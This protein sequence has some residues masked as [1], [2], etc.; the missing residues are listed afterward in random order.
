MWSHYGQAKTIISTYSS[1][2][3]YIYRLSTCP[4]L[5][6]G[7]F[8]TTQPDTPASSLP[9]YASAR[10]PNS[11][12]P[13]RK[14]VLIAHVIA[15]KRESPVV[16]DNAMNVGGHQEHGRTIAIHSLAVL[17]QYQRRNLGKTL[18]KAYTQRMESA[19]IADRIALLAHPHLSKFYEEQGFSNKGESKCKSHGGGWHDL[20]L[21]LLLASSRL[22]GGASANGI[23]DIRIFRTWPRIL[24]LRISGWSWND[25]PKRRTAAGLCWCLKRVVSSFAYCSKSPIGAFPTISIFY[26]PYHAIV[27][28]TETPSWGLSI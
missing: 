13:S 25:P 3:K 21:T 22:R 26:Y 7:L 14:G 10:P 24:R 5:C 28:S 6:L 1:Y 18:L 23:T 9:T 15:T 2:L 8:S 27:F 16:T 4:E 19:G 20:V 12:F 17:P 11:A